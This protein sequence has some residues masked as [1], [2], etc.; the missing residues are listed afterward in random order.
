MAFFD[1]IPS[2]DLSSRLNSD[3]AEMSS[4]LTWVL[5]FTIESSVRVAGAS[6]AEG[7]GERD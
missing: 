7:E 3:T 4:D 6:E 5:R 2:G 1:T